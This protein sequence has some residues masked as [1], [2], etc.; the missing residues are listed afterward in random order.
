MVMYSM[1]PTFEPRR[2]ETPP[3]K[4]REYY[5]FAMRVVGDFGVS[6]AIPVLVLA[7]LGEY[8]DERFGTGPWFLISGFVLAAVISG[9]I[10]YRKA[11]GY[12]AEFQRLTTTKKQ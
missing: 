7:L 1:P 3:S 12:G 2:V 10:V 11:K 4:N 8:F 6:L 5:L 9:R